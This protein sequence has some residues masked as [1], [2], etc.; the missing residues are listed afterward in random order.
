MLYLDVD[1]VLNPD[2]D[3]DAWP[4][5][6]NRSI[7]VDY[8]DGLIVSFEM[9]LSRQMGLAVSEAAKGQITWHTIF[10]QNDTA[11]R[12]ISRLGWDFVPG[13]LRCVESDNAPTWWKL[14]VMK[15]HNP[16]PGFVWIDDDLFDAPEAVTW[17][18]ERGGLCISPQPDVGLTRDQVTLMADHL[19][20]TW[21]PWAT[22]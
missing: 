22:A 5:F 4:D 21:A 8:G 12:L 13:A 6:D 1:G 11:N 10:N 18:R 17:A 9:R 3:S 7:S 19:E 15:E 14:D 16:A 2:R 20:E